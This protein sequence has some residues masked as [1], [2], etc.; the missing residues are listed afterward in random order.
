ML[1]LLRHHVICRVP[2]N[3]GKGMAHAQMPC[4]NRNAAWMGPVRV[5][6]HSLRVTHSPGA[7]RNVDL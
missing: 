3:R 6:V 5:T 4:V 1:R 7:M 2:E